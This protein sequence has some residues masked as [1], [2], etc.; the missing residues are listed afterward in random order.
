MKKDNQSHFA[1]S[2]FST[3][4][5]LC[6][7]VDFYTFYS[8]QIHFLIR[9]YNRKSSDCKFLFKKIRQAN[10]YNLEDHASV[11]I[12]FLCATY[13]PIEIATERVA[14][15]LYLKI[16][17]RPYTFGLEMSKFLH[18][19]FFCSGRQAVKGSRIRFVYSLLFF[20]FLFTPWSCEVAAQR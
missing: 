18:C 16:H 4:K 13:I 8:R 2:I 17:P 1:A 3:K 9:N 6:F 19:G 20:I 10:P 15:I 12:K 5:F 7:T 14:F 11:T